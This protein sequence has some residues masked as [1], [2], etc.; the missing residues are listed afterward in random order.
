MVVQVL[1]VEVSRND[2]LKP[3]APQLTGKSDADVM[4]FGCGDFARLEALIAVPGDVP[5]VLTV[6]LLG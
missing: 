5:I 1:L 6:L 4:T 2:D 3:I